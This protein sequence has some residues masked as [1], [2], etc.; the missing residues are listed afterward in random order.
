MSA[1]IICTMKICKK[2]KIRRQVFPLS[3]NAYR[4][5]QYL[6]SSFIPKEIHRIDKTQL[7]TSSYKKCGLG[8]QASIV[9]IVLDY[10]CTAE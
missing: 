3:G 6:S 9:E 4:R 1:E 8:E 5:G 10:V 2:E 7:Q